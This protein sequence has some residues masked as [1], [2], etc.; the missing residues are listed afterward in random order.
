M[1][2]GPTS[3]LNGLSANGGLVNVALK[4]PT[5]ETIRNLTVRYGSYNYKTIAADL[6]G[7]VEGLE[8]TTYRFIASGNHADENYAG[9]KDPHEILVAPTVR[10]QGQDLMVEGGLRYSQARTGPATF[11]LLSTFGTERLGPLFAQPRG[12]PIGNPYFAGLTE[13]LT[14]STKQSYDVGR[15]F[16]M[17]VT[18]N[19]SFEWTRSNATY[20]QPFAYNTTDLSITDPSNLPF[21]HFTGGVKVFNRTDRSDIT[22]KYES[23]QV[24]Q[25]LKFGFDY[26]G[27]NNFVNTEQSQFTTDAFTG[28]LRIQRRQTLTAS[29]GL[30]TYD[31]STSANTL[32]YYVLDKV[33]TLDDRLH[34][35]GS[36]RRD[37]H[38][39]TSTPTTN[40]SGSGTPT[41][42]GLS[43]VAGAAFDVTPWMTVYGNRSNGFIPTSSIDRS[44]NVLPPEG[45]DLAEVGARYALFDKRLNLTTSFYDLVRT[46]VA[47]TDPT[48]PTGVTAI[49]VGGQNS[50][51]MEIEAQGEVLPGLNLIASLTSQTFEGGQDALTGRPKHLASLWTTYTLQDGPLA[52]L[53]FGAGVRR[54]GNFFVA[55]GVSDPVVF[56]FN[57]YNT[58]DAAVSYQGPDYTVS[59]KVNNILNTYALSPSTVTILTPIQGRNVTLQATYRF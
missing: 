47:N 58:F 17:D 50:K 9:Y 44:G 48:D 53:T 29:T 57:G 12:V 11:A 15:I 59:L 49:L 46:N 1:L 24:K 54:V 43:W 37:D 34:I 31:I 5:S 26:L 22:M 19:H 4:Q 23:E 41:I 42:S 6:G 40:T 14:L 45:R 38:E 51:G 20:N 39:Q 52:G 13:N 16:G 28:L 27:Y 3:I 8:G 33:D 25:T 7:R 55:T 35:F 36:V 10:W 56:R 32:G 30:F 18:L 21:Y 2:K